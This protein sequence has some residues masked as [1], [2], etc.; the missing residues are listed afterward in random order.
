MRGIERPGGLEIDQIGDVVDADLGDGG[1][2]LLA[3]DDYDPVVNVIARVDS[4]EDQLK[5]RIESNTSHESQ[6]DG[7]G[8][9]DATVIYPL[10]VK[11]HIEASSG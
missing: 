10:L 8:R 1:E 2:S 6:I 11:D 5:H 3:G 9:V 4:L 7:R